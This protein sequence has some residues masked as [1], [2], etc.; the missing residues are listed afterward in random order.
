MDI[1]QVIAYKLIII[2]GILVY[3]FSLIGNLL[4]ICVF[5]KWSRPRNN[6]NHIHNNNNNNNVRTSN[7]PLYLLVSSCANFIKIVYPVLTCIIF[8]DFQH[9]KTEDNVF[10]TC[11]FRYYVLH[12]SDL[13]SLKCICMVTLD[14]Y[15]ISSREASLR[16]LSPTLRKSKLI[17]L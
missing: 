17:I 16:R 13:I 11:K 9:P 14:R 10:V 2:L 8:D 1:F 4:N 5:I 3:I 7:S 6:A 12:K 15:L